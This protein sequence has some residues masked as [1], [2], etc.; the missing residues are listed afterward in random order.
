MSFYE[1][2]KAITAAVREESTEHLPE[3]YQRFI[4][5]IVA[6]IGKL[7]KAGEVSLLIVLPISEDQYYIDYL[8]RRMRDDELLN[9]FRI[10]DEISTEVRRVEISWAT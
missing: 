6:D 8:V 3:H 1:D 4:T 5:K 2:I 7:A 10:I 9:G